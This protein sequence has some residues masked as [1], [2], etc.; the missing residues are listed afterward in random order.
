MFSNTFLHLNLTV[1]SCFPG[2]TI[3]R[4]GD[5]GV[6]WDRTLAP[7]GRLYLIIPLNRSLLPQA[8]HPV[9]LTVLRMCANLGPAVAT[10][11]ES[12][13]PNNPPAAA[14]NTWRK[15]LQRFS[16]WYGE[17]NLPSSKLGWDEINPDRWFIHPPSFLS[18]ILL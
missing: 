9:C 13:T 2:W 15:P 18:F 4:V 7:M 8:R 10:H 1:T 17:T 5:R 12:G 6:I 3:R 14:C 11:I 16:R